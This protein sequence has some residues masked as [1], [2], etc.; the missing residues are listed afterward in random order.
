MKAYCST[1]SLAITEACIYRIKSCRS[2][3]FCTWVVVYCVQSP[4]AHNNIASCYGQTLGVLGLVIIRACRHTFC[5]A[6][7]DSAIVFYVAHGRWSLVGLWDFTIE[8][9]GKKIPPYIPP[10]WDIYHKNH[11]KSTITITKPA[12]QIRANWRLSDLIGWIHKH[13]TLV[14]FRR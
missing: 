12:N 14:G 13:P 1:T 6:H 4:A 2:V 3:A 11:H 7:R 9:C 8:L 10:K 5:K